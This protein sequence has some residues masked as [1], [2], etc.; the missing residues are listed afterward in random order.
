MGI[1][2]GLINFN[3]LLPLYV[4]YA[5]FHSPGY[6]CYQSENGFGELFIIFDSVDSY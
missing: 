2:C 1:T 3:A 6:Y 4:Y 5:F